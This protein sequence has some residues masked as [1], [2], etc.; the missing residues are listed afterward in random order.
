MALNSWLSSYGVK[1][2]KVKTFLPIIE[3]TAGSSFP[4]VRTEAMNFYRECYK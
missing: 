4:A 3:T 1:K 2:V